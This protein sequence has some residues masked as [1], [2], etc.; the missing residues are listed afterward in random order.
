MYSQ[1]HVL[2]LEFLSFSGVCFA[3]DFAGDLPK[4]L[5]FCGVLS[6]LIAEIFCNECNVVQCTIAD[7][8]ERCAFSTGLI[9]SQ[10]VNV[11]QI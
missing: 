9:V 7:A 5:G 4:I 8:C 1:I 3:L 6:K 2:F 11:M 10:I